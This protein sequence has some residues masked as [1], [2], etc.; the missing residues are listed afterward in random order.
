MQQVGNGMPATELTGAVWRKS[1]YSN[2]SGC[3][4]ELTWASPPTPTIAGAPTSRPAEG[5]TWT[6][7]HGTA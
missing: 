4:V 3:C 2:P 7:P 5:G 1:R 6:E